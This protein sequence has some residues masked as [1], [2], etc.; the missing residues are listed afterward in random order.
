MVKCVSCGLC[1][2]HCPTFRL[3][4]LETASPRGRIAAMRAV[5]EG[6]AAV[7][8]LVHAHD[9]RVP[10]V[11]GLRGGVPQRRALRAHD[12]GR[13]RPGRA[14][15]HRARPR[16]PPPRPDRRAAAAPAGAG[17]GL[18]AGGR[19]RAAAR[20][21]GPRRAAR[22]DAAREPGADAHP[23]PRRAGRRPGGQ[24]ALG[25]RDG[26]GLPTHPARDHA[27]G[28]RRRLPGDPHAGG[29]LLRRARHALRPTR[30]GP[31]HG[32]G[33]CRRARRRGAG[34]RQ[35]VGMQ[36]AREGL[37]R[38]ARR[39]PRVGRARRARRR[40]HEGPDRAG[41][42]AARRGARR[43]WPCTTP[44]TTSTPRASDPATC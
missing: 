30:G 31:R 33:A 4:G 42:P 27:A 41:A 22:R 34:G 25:L 7:D 3:T 38:A 39:R 14:H 12:R 35:R 10:G 15:A 44:A 8:A 6:E 11:P 29:R 20:P 9:G 40:A 32:A 43:A 19:A 17:R 28:G 24:G 5:E 16:H 36:R 21:A 23:D 37:R 26:R 18:G 13:P 2:P 1:L